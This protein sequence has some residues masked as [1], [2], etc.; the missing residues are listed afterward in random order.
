MRLSHNHVNFINR[1]I[2]LTT[3]VDLNHNMSRFSRLPASTNTAPLQHRRRILRMA[4]VLSTP[5]QTV[6]SRVSRTRH[7]TVNPNR[8][9]VN[10]LTNVS[11]TLPITIT[12]NIK[13][14]HIMRLRMHLPRQRPHNIIIN[15]SQTSFS[16]TR[17]C[18]LARRLNRNLIL[19]VKT[20]NR[21]FTRTNSI[22]NHTILTRFTLTLRAL[23]K[24][25]G[26]SSNTR[27]TISMI[28]K[29]I[30]SF[31]QINTVHFITVNRHTSRHIRTLNIDRG[32]DT[33]MDIRNSMI[34]N[35]RSFTILN[36]TQ[37]RAKTSMNINPN[38]GRRYFN[39][40]LRIFPLQVNLNRVPMRYTVYAFYNLRR[41]QGVTNLRTLLAID[42][43][44]N[45][46]HTRS[47]L[48]RFQRVFSNR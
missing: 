12:S 18:S 4:K 6:M 21:P 23:S 42:S 29:H 35:Q 14:L 30:N 5:I 8:H 33:T 28:N 13:R 27:R 34:P 10:Q 19:H 2:G 31:P 1:P 47:L 41:R 40:I 32:F 39:T 43:R 7:I 37:M 36:F 22:N 11:R 25:H 45:G 20:N 24:R 48:L 3:A 9:Q 46:T 44:R 16:R 17:N 38:G 26:P 15:N